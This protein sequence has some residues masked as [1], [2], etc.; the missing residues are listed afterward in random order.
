MGY[1]PDLH[2]F[3]LIGGPVSK[4]SAEFG[5]WFWNGNAD[6]VVCRVEPTGVPSIAH[7]EGICPAII[8]GQPRIVLVSDDGDRKAGR[9]ARFLLLEPGQ[10][11]MGSEV[12][13]PAS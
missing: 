5:L 3:L 4:A 6:G 10:L 9:P 12:R 13:R 1:V 7:A 11:M 8:D 2:G